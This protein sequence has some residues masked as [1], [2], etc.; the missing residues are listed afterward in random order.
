MN[1]KDETYF[2]ENSSNSQTASL[3]HPLPPSSCR[4]SIIIISINGIYTWFAFAAANLRHQNEQALID[5]TKH[6]IWSEDENFTNSWGSKEKVTIEFSCF[7]VLRTFCT[8]LYVYIF[9]KIKL[10]KHIRSAYV[11]RSKNLLLL[12]VRAG[13]RACMS[14]C[15][16]LLFY[17]IGR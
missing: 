4:S 16:Q 10:C 7:C 13:W 3:H 15:T 14:T 1:V 2:I 5:V 9:P 17:P 6:G 8:H 12:S 11:S